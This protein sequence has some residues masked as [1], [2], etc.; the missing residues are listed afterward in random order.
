MRTI[1]LLAVGLALAGVVPGGLAAQ[2]QRPIIDMHLHAPTDIRT[3]NGAIRMRPCNPSPCQGTPPTAK[4]AGD[5][6]T[7]TLEAMD[8]NNIVLGFLSQWPLD[9]VY[10]WVEAAPD[11]FIASPLVR[12]P[13]EIDLRALRKAYESGRLG[14]MGELANQYEGIEATDPKLRP[15]FALAEEFDVPVLIHH[16]GTAGPSTQFRISMGHPEQLE[17]VLVT[18][19]NLRLV[20]ETS[21]FPFLE[22]TIA[23]MYRYPQVYGDLSLWKYPREAFHWYLRG[24][25]DAGLGKR[26]M[27]GSDQ[28]L[29]PDTVIDDEI[30]AIESAAFLSEAQKRD[31]FYNNAALF[32]RLS[33]TQIA[34][35]HRE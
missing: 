16:H 20:I 1:T 3:P 27:F 34:E 26:L 11:R 10:R 2:E 12:D 4:T 8:R 9:D 21:G 31:I 22:E 35:H 29:W 5:V 17:E 24:L 28:M 23:L 32:L 18:H 19:P 6:L 25:I 14:G 33:D 13:D 7:L 30:E 15:F